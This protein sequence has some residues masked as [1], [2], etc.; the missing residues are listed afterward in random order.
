MM[1]V[2]RKDFGLAEAFST[3]GIKFNSEHD[4]GTW[5]HSL[6]GYQA[7][8]RLDEG[9]L[10]EARDVAESVYRREHLTRLMRMVAT[11]VLALTRFR[12]GDDA[13]DQRLELALADAT[14]IGELQYLLPSRLGLIEAAW[15]KGDADLTQ[16]HV[17]SL[18]DLPLER[19]NIWNFGDAS[20]WLHRTTLTADTRGSGRAIPSP[21]QLE[22]AVRHGEAGEDQFR[23]LRSIVAPT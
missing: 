9:R 8:V 6:Y 19:L 21:R 22:I 16:R 18:K 15:L 3:R 23:G 14:S 4:V 12:L 17:A 10:T 20:V 13:D 2:S 11:N 1:S 7:Q 5:V